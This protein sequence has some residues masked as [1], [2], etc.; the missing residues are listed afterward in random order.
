[1]P[2]DNV[3]VPHAKLREFPVL[4][5]NYAQF[6]KH[7]HE[8]LNHLAANNCNN[9]TLHFN[10]VDLDKLLQPATVVRSGQSAYLFP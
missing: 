1:M 9:P 3:T 4:E 5:L 7:T 8:L 6:S 10:E 2:V